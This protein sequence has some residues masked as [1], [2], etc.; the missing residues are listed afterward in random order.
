MKLKDVIPMVNPEELVVSGWDIN[1]QDSA[2]AMKRAQVFD[3]EIQ[4]KL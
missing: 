2:T 3:L 4:Q 1:A